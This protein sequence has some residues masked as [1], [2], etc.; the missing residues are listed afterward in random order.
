MRKEIIKQIKNMK[1]KILRLL[2]CFTDLN[3]K[4]IQ[5][6]RANNIVMVVSA[7]LLSYGIIQAQ[8]VTGFGYG[9]YNDVNTGSLDYGT[10]SNPFT[11][12]YSGG[13]YT[14]KDI[15]SWAT[16]NRPISLSN[17]VQ[18]AD[19]LELGTVIL[20]PFVPPVATYTFH[21][22]L[23][24]S[25]VMF[26][27]DVDALESFKIEFLDVSGV[28]L[29]PNILGTYNLSNIARSS[30]TLNPTFLTVTALDNTNYQ[31]SLSNFVINSNLVKQV[32]ITQIAGRSDIV[33]Y[34]SAEFYFAAP[35]TPTSDSES[36]LGNAPGSSVTLDLL[37]GDLLGNGSQATPGLVTVNFIP[38]AGGTVS[39]NTITVIGE[40]IWTYD[41]TTGF[42][43]FN[44]E[45]GF[46]ENPTILTYTIS[47]TATGLSSNISSQT[48]TYSNLPVDLISFSGK[49][50]EEGVKLTW[51]TANEVNFSHFEIL[52]NVS[53]AKDFESIGKVLSSNQNSYNYDDNTPNEGINYYKLRMIDLDGTSKLSRIISV[54]FENRASLAFGR[55]LEVNFNESDYIY[56][57][58]NPTSKVLYMN[59]ID[60]KKVESIQIFNTVG[61]IVMTTKFCSIGGI[62]IA[63]LPNGIY[64]TK[65]ILTDGTSLTHKI[66]VSK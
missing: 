56:F 13:I 48:V 26:I 37:T 19:M 34:G 31:E 8:D 20:D 27:Q 18:P 45:T 1:T 16:T 36:S 53:N 40:G 43:T 10:I 54:N 47:E 66:I 63:K 61:T 62:D 52:K 15:Q 2:K 21:S 55:T 33:N 35:A 32:R 39:G 7:L 29:D 60:P 41:S 4:V 57:Y 58:P 22:P 9:T 49:Q 65:S 51:R 17:Y 44:P 24:K 38:P 46:Y 30:V 11:L 3:I 42:I 6:F 59:G 28:A 14:K 5:I 12:T 64:F 50:I 23:P 25:T